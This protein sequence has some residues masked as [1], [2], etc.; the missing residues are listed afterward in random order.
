MINIGFITL[1]ILN[2]SCSFTP[3]KA[4]KEK[5]FNTVDRANF[6]LKRAKTLRYKGKI[7]E[8]MSLLE[9][10]ALNYL[11]S[12]SKNKYLLTKVQVLLLSISNKKNLRNQQE[13]KKLVL[14]NHINNLGQDI[15]LTVLKIHQYKQTGKKAP[16]Q[17]LVEDLLKRTKDNLR[18]QIYF[19]SLKLEIN[20][21]NLPISFLTM[22][23][24]K[25]N[26]FIKRRFQGDEEQNNL[27]FLSKSSFNLGKAYFKKNKFKEATFWF[28]RNYNINKNL[29]HYVK[30]IPT[31][32]LLE[33][34][35][36]K[37]NNNKK[38]RYYKNLK[39]SYEQF[40]ESL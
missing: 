9:K 16:A 26:L 37:L 20:N 36:K 24:E 12:G 21:F 39:M 1:L 35:F 22:M 14:F 17:K 18:K 13:F 10:A 30:I 25:V 3:K 11:A 40:L 34:S 8:S 15:P 32:Y 27:E 28:E 33:K 23:E 4:P 6:L 5:L 29:Q 7:K 38:Q 2:L 19:L 31:L